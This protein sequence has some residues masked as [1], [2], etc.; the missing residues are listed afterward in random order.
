M[1][2]ESNVDWQLALSPGTD[3]LQPDKTSGHGNDTIH[4]A[5]L[6]DNDDG[7]LRTA[8]LT[9]SSVNTPTSLQA[10]L[11]I[12]QKIYNVHL[13]S[14]KLLGGTGNDDVSAIVPA[15]DGGLL[16][17][18][19]T[20][21]DRTGIVGK[22]HGGSDLWLVRLNMNLDTMWTRVMGGSGTDNSQAASSGHKLWSKT[23]G[24][25]DDELCNALM[26]NA[27]N[28]FYIAGNVKSNNSGDVG[29]TYGSMDGWLIKIED[30]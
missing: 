30:Y 10:Q 2:V 18:G 23:F 15:S 14:Q 4:I 25:A 6:N 8:S 22:N 21:S 28:S 20:Y 3:W 13:V 5:V 16:L 24:G 1:I 11:T 12:E 9:I 17:V 27:D 7:Q 29:P 19:H 26:V